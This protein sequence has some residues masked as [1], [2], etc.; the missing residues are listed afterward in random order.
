MMQFISRNVL[1]FS[2]FSFCN[3]VSLL[4]CSCPG[5]DGGGGGISAGVGGD[6]GG[7]GDGGVG[8]ECGG[9]GAMIQYMS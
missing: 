5:F 2:L 3:A 6:C 9:G 8:G 4:Q 1:I 7:D